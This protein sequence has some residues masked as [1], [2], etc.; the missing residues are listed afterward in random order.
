MDGA[1]PKPGSQKICSE[2]PN[3]VRFGSLADIA[4]TGIYVCFAPESGRDAA[5]ASRQLWATR[6]H[7][8]CL[9]DGYFLFANSLAASRE[10]SHSPSRSS[11][12]RILPRP[13]KVEASAAG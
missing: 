5:I 10:S 6:R 9:A 13:I 8:M 11:K 4:K 3:G 2:V 7:D 1:Y 12:L